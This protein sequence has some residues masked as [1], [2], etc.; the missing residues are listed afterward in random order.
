MW[1]CVIREGSA[2]K[3]GT[4]SGG[5]GGGWSDWKRVDGWG[6]GNGGIEGGGGGGGLRDWKRIDGRGIGMGGIEGGGDW[7]NGRG[8]NG[9]KCSGDKGRRRGRVVWT[10]WLRRYLT[11]YAEAAGR[12]RGRVVWKD[13]CSG[14]KGRRRGRGRGAW[15]VNDGSTPW[16]GTL[17]IC[18]AITS[19]GCG[20]GRRNI[21]MGLNKGGGGG[22][23]WRS[24]SMREDR[25]SG[26]G[27]VGGAETAKNAVR[28]EG[29]IEVR[30]AVR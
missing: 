11:E 5:D 20:W 17:L 29:N 18:V 9:D 13:Q 30:N 15:K 25:G 1:R 4:G 8:W 24:G 6:D 12:R 26:N 7:R 3:E 16:N 10:D 23:D 19:D 22:G 14:V 2:A 28:G 27:R 21:G